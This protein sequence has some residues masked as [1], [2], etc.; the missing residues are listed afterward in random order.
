M[1]SGLSEEIVPEQYKVALNRNHSVLAVFGL[2]AS[3]NTIKKNISILLQL[4][5][6]NIAELNVNKMN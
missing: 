4:N 5:E 3:A 6:E 2:T 1:L